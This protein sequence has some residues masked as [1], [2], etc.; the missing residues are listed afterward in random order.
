MV[1]RQRITTRSKRHGLTAVAV[2]AAVLLALGGCELADATQDGDAEEPKTTASTSEQTRKTVSMSDYEKPSDAELRE[3]L[4]ALQYHVTQRCGT[5]PAFQNEYWDNHAHGIYVDVV[6]GEP[7][8]SSLDKYDSGSGWPSFTR[9]LEQ[10]SVVNKR[11]SSFFMERIEVR[12]K[13]AD[14]HLG[15]VFDDGPQPTGLRY[16]INS[17]SLRFV[18]V[19][20]MA[21]EGYGAYLAAFEE[22][23]VIEPGGAAE[24]N[25][26]ISAASPSTSSVEV[27]TLAGGCFW[28]VE[29]LFRQLDGVTDTQ[30]GYT[31]G[32]T[33][34]PTYEQ[35][36]SGRTG[37]AEAIQITFDPA[38]VSYE[39]VLRYFF[40][41]H[42]PTTLNRQHNDIG[43]QYR[44]AIFYHDDRQRQI[45]ERVTQQVDASGE[46]KDP[47][48]T[49]IVAASEFHDAEQYHQ[50]YL[51]KN[52]G[53]YN[54]HFLRD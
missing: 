14:S 45:A 3:D 17:A 38:Q 15:H 24:A 20:Q 31:G 48:V 46:W 44:S 52:P 22:A 40:R 27:A 7:L 33:E 21:A 8:F 51:V 50:D 18:P 42:D 35:I 23:G 54:C 5:E 49:D 12:S 1:E 53:G 11:D 34:N 43:T 47:V 30:V 26:A 41:L 25:A 13:H 2:C 9:P 32:T 16:C 28:G 37:H 36:C 4:D 29:Q 10:E 39:E 19:E 6:S